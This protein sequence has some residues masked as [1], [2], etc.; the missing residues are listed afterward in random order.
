MSKKNIVMATNLSVWS[1]GKGIGAPSFYKTIELYDKSYNIYFYTTEKNL[2]LSEFSN[3]N[4]INL[5]VLPIINTRYLYTVNRI[6]NYILYQL[7]FL[8]F[9]LF[10]Q[11]EKTDLLYGYE[12][13]FI[14]ALKIVSMILKKPFVTRFQGTILF[15]KMKRRF[16]K[17]LYFPH[18]LSIKI[19][20]TLTI[21][22][23][24]GT[25]GDIVIEKLRGTLENVIFLKNGVDFIKDDVTKIS[26]IVSQLADEMNFFTYNFISVSRL[27]KWK[28]VDRSLDVFKSFQESYRNSRFIIVGDGEEREFLEKYTMYNSID[29]VIF[30][31]GLNAYEVNFLMKNS[32]I[33]LSHY[34]LS[35][36]GNPLWEAMNNQCLIV[37]IKNGD[38]GKII[39]DGYSGIISNEGHYRINADKIIKVLQSKVTLDEIVS[40]ATITLHGNVLSWEGRMDL[41]RNAVMELL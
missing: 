35:N 11:K 7:I 13:E 19:K 12:I 34:E 25:L 24:D 8:F 1:I 26:L 2:D 38:T 15:P 40:N 16:W 23:D 22:T 10:K 3:M 28:R 36:V 21:M 39:I 33:F 30:T 5:P 6:F 17:L 14:P 32:N 27:Q 18:Y 9:Y 31:G 41:E 29:N 37:T 20:S 4:I